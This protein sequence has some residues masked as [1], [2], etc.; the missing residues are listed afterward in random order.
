MKKVFKVISGTVA[1]VNT[2]LE[3]IAHLPIYH[4]SVNHDG[5]EISVAVHYG[6]EAE[7]PKEVEEKKDAE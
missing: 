3:K 4:V 5:K 7:Q 2:E 6:E 1:K